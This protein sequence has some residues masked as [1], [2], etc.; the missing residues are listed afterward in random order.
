MLWCFSKLIRHSLLDLQLLCVKCQTKIDKFLLN[1]SYLSLGGGHFLLGQT[2][3]PVHCF[4]KISIN[5]N[6]I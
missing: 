1:Y 5:F 6:K 4:N 2:K 3:P